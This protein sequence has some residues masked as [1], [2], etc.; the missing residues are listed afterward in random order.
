MARGAA[1]H[2]EKNWMKGIPIDHCVNH[3]MAHIVKFMEGDKT[4]NHLAHAACNLLM[5]L[6]FMEKENDRSGNHRT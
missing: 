5:S 6:H 3:A 1:N 4:E 2:G